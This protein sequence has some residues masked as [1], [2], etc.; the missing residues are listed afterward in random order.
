MCFIINI[1]IFQARRI[2]K[3]WCPATRWLLNNVQQPWLTWRASWPSSDKTINAERGAMVG[4][5]CHPPL[6]ITG[7]SGCEFVI[8]MYCTQ[9]F[10]VSQWNRNDEP[11]SL[12]LNRLSCPTV[13]SMTYCFKIPSNGD[14]Q[15][16]VMVWWTVPSGIWDCHRGESRQ[17]YKIV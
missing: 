8:S 2:I 14:P 17:C 1:K 5:P 15:N 16:G 11:C 4:H 3:I 6:R 9:R 13:K 10:A 12:A 7:H